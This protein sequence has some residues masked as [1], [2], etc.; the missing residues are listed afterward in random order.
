ML[1]YTAIPLRIV[2]SGLV[3]A[4]PR[5]RVLSI[6]ARQELDWSLGAS[7]GNN[8]TR[9][10]SEFVFGDQDHRHGRRRARMA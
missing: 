2:V 4:P 10:A 9:L 7:L 1:R 3:G 8:F 5:S 6:L